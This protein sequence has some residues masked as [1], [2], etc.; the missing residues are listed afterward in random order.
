MS[1]SFER[2]RVVA[3][4]GDNLLGCVGDH[5]DIRAVRQTGSIICLRGPYKLRGASASSLSTCPSSRGCHDVERYFAFEVD[6]DEFAC[7]HVSVMTSSIPSY[8]VF[9]SCSREDYLLKSG[10]CSSIE[11]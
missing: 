2:K 7:I 10:T 3:R 5:V 6:R 9:V 11:N 4:I 1:E 8:D